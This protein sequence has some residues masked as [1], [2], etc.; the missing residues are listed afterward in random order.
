M[1]RNHCHPTSSLVQSLPYPIYTMTQA[2]QPTEEQKVWLI[3]GKFSPP[4]ILFTQL[5]Y[6][7]L[8]SCITGASSG[9]GKRLATS[10][11]KRGDLVIATSRSTKAPA[12]FEE[13]AGLVYRQ[14]DVDSGFENISKVVEECISI[15]GRIDVCVNNAGTV[16]PAMLEEAGSALLRQQ[17][18][19]NLFGLLDVT[20]AVL[21]HMRERKSGTLV[22]CSSR[23]S[24]RTD[25]PG[26][27]EIT[28]S[29]HS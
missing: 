21:P 18:E 12:D 16:L 4:I 24:W 2:P 28:S 8:S 7:I 11:H 13:S 15:W 19:T 9:F 20:N 17:L 22:M 1:R 5:T 6:T 27:S 3:T 14:L 29:S 25:V 23:S 10:A 26:L